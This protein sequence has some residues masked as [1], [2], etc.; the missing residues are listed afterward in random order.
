MVRSLKMQNVK[1][2]C[3]L[4]HMSIEEANL[5]ATLRTAGSLVGHV[6]FADSNRRPVGGGHTD[7]A[8]I[9]KAH[10]GHRL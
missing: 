6:H 4:F 5:A 2:L 3:D 9:A 7:F 1:L 8:P 10:G